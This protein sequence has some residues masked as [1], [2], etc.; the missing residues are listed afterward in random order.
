[1]AQT[2]LV[3]ELLKKSRPGI[4]IEISTITTHGDQDRGEPLWKL[5]GTGFF[6]SRIESALLEEKADFAVHSFKDLPT[7]LAQGLEIAA[8]CERRFVEDVAVVRGPFQQIIELPDGA[9]IGTSSL[10]RIA[11]IRRRFPQFEMATIR[12]NVPTRLEKV[13]SE[14]DAIVIARAGIERLGLAGKYNVERFD[15]LEFLPAPAQGA[16]AIQARG[17]DKEMFEVLS[18]IDNKNDRF[19]CEAERAFLAAMEGGCHAPVGAYARIARRQMLLR[20]F[21]SDVD[22]RQ[23]L[24]DEVAGPAQ[25]RFELAAELA[26]KLYAAGAKAIMEELKP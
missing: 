12:G 21:V 16:L 20:G 13:G 3:V 22:G 5:E 7:C 1:M 4:Q 26:K 17:D 24:C 19:T 25:G 15:P 6:T 11:Q 18:A 10:R 9:K 8:V 23:Y 2:Q 14:F